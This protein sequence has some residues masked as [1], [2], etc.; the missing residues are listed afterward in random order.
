[1]SRGCGRARAISTLAALRHHDDGRRD[2]RAEPSLLQSF[3]CIATGARCRTWHGGT[4]AIAQTHV[5]PR[6]GWLHRRRTEIAQRR[7]AVS[8]LAGRAEE[9]HDTVVIG[10][11]PRT[12]ATVSSRQWNAADVILECLALGNGA[13]PAVQI[14]HRRPLLHELY[15]AIAHD[16]DGNV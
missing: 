2:R 5:H 6:G 3:R 9:P 16:S 14:R 8:R 1:R 10:T 11:K 15:E 7:S 12:C 13:I 4:D